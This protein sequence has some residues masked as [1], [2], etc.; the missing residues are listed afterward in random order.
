MATYK[1]VSGFCS[2]TNRPVGFQLQEDGANYKVVGSFSITPGTSSSKASD[3]HGKIFN[4]GFKCKCCGNRGFIQ[5]DC[6]NLVCA[7]PS[8]PS[9][10]CPNCR[11]E[12]QLRV[13]SAD[14]VTETT[15][16][17]MKQ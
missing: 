10:T 4:G 13:I 12:W 3:L 8:A 6:G 9:V 16:K 1:T 7:D 2:K 15:V 11:K 5:C 17:G 14:E